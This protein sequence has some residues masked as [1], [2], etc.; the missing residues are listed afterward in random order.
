MGRMLQ[1]LKHGDGRRVLPASDA[2]LPDAAVQ[3]TVVDWEIAE[4]VPFVEVGGPNKKIELSPS[5]LSH[6]AQ[7]SPQP[8]HHP[9][10]IAA[11]PKTVHLT[12]AQPMGV[13][14]QSL[15]APTT[16][17]GQVSADVVAYHQPEHATSKEYAH[18]LDAMLAMTKANGVLMLVG[19]K[20]NVGASTV[21]LNLAAIAAQAKKLR[22]AL[23]ETNIKQAMA[24]RLGV[25][26]SRGLDDVL[27]GSLAMEQALAKTP[28]A[29]LDVLPAGNKCGVLT[30]EAVAW[31]CA[32]LRERFD[33]V[34]IDG[35]TLD[36]AAALT[37]LL[38][39]THGVYLVLPQGDSSGKGLAHSINR[40]GGQVCGLIHTHFEM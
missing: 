27:A 37:V 7:R 39:H 29:A 5:L 34:L 1:T 28:I 22:V 33:L 2:A 17:A 13:A 12:P 25:S 38:P 20:P 32:W 19:V 9:V 3:D 18:L 16:A 36:D 30:S 24:Q 35:P 6:P 15:S 26:S 31:V 11:K 14:F 4:E 40:L 21:L 8:P 10:E 23:V